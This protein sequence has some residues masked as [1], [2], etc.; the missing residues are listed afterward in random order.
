MKNLDSMARK[1]VLDEIAKLMSESED[2]KL[3]SMSPK[4]TKVDIQSDD[5]Q[6]AEKLKNKVMSVVQDED[7]MSP[8][9]KLS[10]DDSDSDE[11]SD[12]E[13]LKMLLQAIK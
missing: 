8:E 7:E 6:L 3:K 10:N 1:K 12:E 11:M 5:P 2:D 13:K 4:F 9:D